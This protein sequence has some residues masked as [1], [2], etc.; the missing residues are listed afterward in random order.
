MICAAAAELFR[1]RGFRGTSIDDIG[2]AVG[3][4]GPA[5]YRHF[6]SK[7]ALLAE[8][9][10]RALERARS[11]CEASLA[12]GGGPRAVLERLVARSVAQVALEGQL[13]MVA[14]REMQSLGSDAKARIARRQRAVVQVWVETLRKLRPEL[15]EP[16]AVAVVIG[17]AAL[18][19]ASSR[20][21]G[22]AG[23]AKHELFRRMAL[24]ALLARG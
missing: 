21:R 16:E 23:E 1:E 4:T 14:A 2:A 13:V 8:L 22:V 15:G 12:E 10:E 20:V 6:P 9:L 19:N 17:V 7:E 18:L 11:D 3:M 24:A 5:L